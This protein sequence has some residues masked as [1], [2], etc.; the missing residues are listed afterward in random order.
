MW[1]QLTSSQNVRPGDKIR[2]IDGP[3]F[4]NAETLFRVVR[5]DHHYF[6]I[7]CEPTN[8]NSAQPDLSRKVVRY[9]DIGYNVSMEVW[10][11]G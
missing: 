9:F 4:V 3:S 7:L 2:Y 11:D 5:T 1:K 8:P 6:E 10:I